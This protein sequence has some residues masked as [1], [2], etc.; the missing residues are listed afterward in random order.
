MGKKFLK[1]FSVLIFVSCF[2]TTKIF[3]EKIKTK[4]I[5]NVEL[6]KSE[7]EYI[8]S[9]KI[10]NFYSAWEGIRYRYGG[11]S[12]KGIDCSA[13][14]QNL[15]RDKFSLELPRTTLTQA[16]IGERVS[17]KSE[18][19]V[20]DLIFFKMNKRINHVGVYVGNN[21]FVHAGR[22]TGVTISEYD[23]YWSRRYWQTRRFI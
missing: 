21:K 23:N 22:T 15:Y 10:M 11:T 20:G 16:R 6:T 2:T 4:T 5:K 19:K 7:V 1:I 17:S 3:A 18:W 12:K 13:L 8:K 9:Q 14:V